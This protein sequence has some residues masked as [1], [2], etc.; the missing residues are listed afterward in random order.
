MP[1]KSNLRNDI[2]KIFLLLT[3]CISESFSLHGTDRNKVLFWPLWNGSDENGG[4]VYLTEPFGPRNLDQF[5]KYSSSTG[6]WFHV[7]LD[8]GSTGK[9]KNAYSGSGANGGKAY[10]FDYGGSNSDALWVVTRQWDGGH[11]VAQT[12]HWHVT[13]SGVQNGQTANEGGEFV[14]QVKSPNSTYGTHLHFECFTGQDLNNLSTAAVRN[15]H[16]KDPLK[17][18]W[19]NYNGAYN[20]TAGFLFYDRENSRYY[21]FNT[22]GQ[23]VGVTN[24]NLNNYNRIVEFDIGQ[25]GGKDHVMVRVQQKKPGID[26]SRIEILPS[27]QTADIYFE[28]KY[29]FDLNNRVR[30]YSPSG[31]NADLLLDL[32]GSSASNMN[33]VWYRG[34]RIAS[35][36]WH[37]SVANEKKDVEF[38]VRPWFSISQNQMFSIKITDIYGSGMTINNLGRAV[39]IGCN[40]PPSAPPP[41]SNLS[42]VQTSTGI[43]LNWSP[44]SVSGLEVGYKI[45][46]RPANTPNIAYAD[47][48]AYV[49]STTEYND[50]LSTAANGGKVLPGVRYAYSIAALTINGEG[51]NGPF[52]SSCNW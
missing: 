3:I 6:N 37:S 29:V 9:I 5:N 28:G 52:A 39:C 38:Y 40:P 17:W 46:R 51:C 24:P 45:Y 2:T 32:G 42:A 13:T 36:Y 16:T 23:F 21:H 18:L 4:Y 12:M 33:G 1:Q 20:S 26:I 35:A 22:S 30:Q 8:I 10:V 43:R 7:G 50:L 41:P 31:T 47:P 19:Y 14:F 44:V 34:N 48:I 27:N 25:D 49:T 15:I 11:E